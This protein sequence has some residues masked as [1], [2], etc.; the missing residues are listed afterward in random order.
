MK[1]H[2][3]A[4]SFTR[5]ENIFRKVWLITLILF[6]IIIT[7]SFLVVIFFSIFEHT[8]IFRTEGISLIDM[9]G[10]L[11]LFWGLFY[12]NYRC[13][14]KKMGTK[15]L[16]CRLILLTPA[17]LGVLIL[18]ISRLHIVSILAFLAVSWVFLIDV[19]MC[20]INLKYKK[21]CNYSSL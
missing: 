11:L 13:S 8:N 15:L 7:L 19:V 9:I 12:I 10:I 20:K 3:I 18:V 4:R 14:Y 5:V 16:F 2:E 17:F 21:N 6:P 1:N